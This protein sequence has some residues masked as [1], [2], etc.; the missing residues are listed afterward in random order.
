MT[1]NEENTPTQDA[2]PKS[3]ENFIQRLRSNPDTALAIVCVAF[4]IDFLLLLSCI[5]IFP[6]Y[7]DIFGLNHLR[8]L[9]TII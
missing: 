4:F 5:P 3:N 1:S 8:K 7:T 2:T 6:H 9:S